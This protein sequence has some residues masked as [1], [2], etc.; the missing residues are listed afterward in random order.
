MENN[1][2][3]DALP[4]LPSPTR[5]PGHEHV[6]HSWGSF[7]YRCWLCQAVETAHAVDAKKPPTDRWEAEA[8]REGAFIWWARA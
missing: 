7:F 3:W 1:I 6:W 5:L 2:S 8:E 4:Q